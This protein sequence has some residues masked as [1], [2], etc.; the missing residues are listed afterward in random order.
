MTKKS[1]K[2]LKKP[3]KPKFLYGELLLGIKKFIRGTQS[4]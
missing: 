4:V 2:I 1:K 3:E